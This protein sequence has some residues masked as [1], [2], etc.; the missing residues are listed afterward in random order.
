MLLVGG[1]YNESLK[2]FSDT[3]RLAPA[4]VSN[5]I[6]AHQCVISDN[7]SQFTLLMDTQVWYS[8]LNELGNLFTWQV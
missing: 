3:R 4:A 6:F 8:L 2:Y 1:F 7:L 5:Y